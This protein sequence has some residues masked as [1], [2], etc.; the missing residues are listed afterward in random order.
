MFINKTT[1][2][3]YV[4]SVKVMSFLLLCVGANS[5]SGCTYCDIKGEYSHALSKIVYL[6]HRRYLAPH[7]PLRYESRNFPSQSFPEQPPAPKNMAYVDAANTA[8][9][10][11]KTVTKRKEISRSKGCKGSYSL[12]K[13]PFHERLL[14]TPVEPMHLI[15]DIVEHIV[16]LLCGMEDSVKVRE[17]ERERN[18]FRTSWVQTGKPGLP[19]APFRLSVGEIRIANERAKSVCVPAGFDWKPSAVFSRPVG[20]KSHS[21]KQM[22]STSILKYCLRGLLGKRQRETLF[23]LC[24]VLSRVCVEVVDITLLN[25]LEDDV[26]RALVLLERDFP[27]SLHVI[28]FHLLHH[29]PF[30]I[31]RFGPIY[32]FWMYPYERFNSWLIRRIK[33]RRYPEAT[34]IETYRLYEWAQYLHMAEQLPQ[35]SL[36]CPDDVEGSDH[37]HISLLTTLDLSQLSHLQQ[38]YMEAVP[39]YKSICSRYEAEKNRARGRHKLREFPPMTSWRP[40]DHGPQLT[41]EEEEMCKPLDGDVIQMN[42]FTYKDVHGRKIQFSSKIADTHNSTSSYIS[43]QLPG[44]PLFI[45]RIAFFFEHKFANE[46]NTFA[47]VEWLGRPQRDKESGILFVDIVL[48]SNV[49][50]VVPTSKLSFPLVVATDMDAPSKLWVLTDRFEV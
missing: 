10:S 11:A 38:Y 14:N 36:L 48:S 49:N 32:S 45:G 37:H 16:R 42:Y 2:I 19:P 47:F 22:V 43:L 33:N 5:Y 13:L 12:R 24:D 44:K 26:H 3:F 23:C 28:V 17:E 25:R 15:K 39:Q 30:Y 6:E 29:L 18:R 31:R 50:P 20:M 21:W 40:S 35:K 41:A 4:H 7:D 46:R 8:Y 34:V 9:D 1:L 27:V